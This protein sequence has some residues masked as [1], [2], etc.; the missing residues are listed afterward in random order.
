MCGAAAATDAARCEHCGA[1]LATVSCPSCFGLVFVGQNFCP[2]CGAKA[3]RQP[4]AEAGKPLPCPSCKTNLEAVALGG[5]TIRECP[6]CEGTWIDGDTLRQICDSREEQSALL[7]MASHAPSG[8]GRNIEQ[9]IRYLPCPVC[10]ELM[11]RVNFANCSGVIVEVCRAHGT[12][13]D[14]EELRA[15]TEYIRDGGLEKSRQREK[16]ELK[17]ER[18][19]LQGE[20]LAALRDSDRSRSIRYGA[21]S[22]VAQAIADSFL[23]P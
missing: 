14:C 17:E 23:D 15:I 8:D 18:R 22:D 2:H 3:E 1:R 21:F 19:K 4:A 9:R 6:Q 5:I 16:E 20:Q 10:G 7:G 11:N 12:W 13:F